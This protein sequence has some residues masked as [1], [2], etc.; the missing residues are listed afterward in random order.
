MADTQEKCRGREEK[1]C[2]STTTHRPAKQF[3]SVDSH[4]RQETETNKEDRG[5]AEQW[6]DGGTI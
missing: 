5:Y 1:N 6:D 2:I 3:K 4:A